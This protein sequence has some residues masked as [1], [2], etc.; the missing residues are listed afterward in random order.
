M[1]GPDPQKKL[2]VLRSRLRVVDDEIVKLLA[3][4][5]GLARE[6]G[7]LK[8]E[9]GIEILDSSREAFNKDRNR[10]ISRGKIPE[11]IIDELSEILAKWSRSVQARG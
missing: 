2:E 11:D 3:T 1:V 5:M 9:H 7:A 8:R 6:I 10:D 4:R